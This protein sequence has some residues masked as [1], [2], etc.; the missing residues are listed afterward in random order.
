MAAKKTKPTTTDQERLRA[1]AGE[2][3]QSTLAVL[4]ALA[5]AGDVAA[6]RVVLAKTLPDLK[7][8]AACVTF[9]LPEGDLTT[10]ADHILK[11]IAA[12]KLPPD[13]GT[14]LISSLAQVARIVELVEF[15]KRLSALEGQ[16]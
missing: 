13:V 4:I 3:A 8:V 9:D 14:A 12:G 7:P 15:D 16:Q 5:R 1:I 6:A 10:K 11:A 2:A